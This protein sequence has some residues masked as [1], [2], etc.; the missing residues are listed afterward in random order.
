MDRSKRARMDLRE[1]EMI[2]T[3]KECTTNARV[4]ILKAEIKEITIRL[5]LKVTDDVKHTNIQI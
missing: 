3:E 2:A 4:S 5:V 1:I